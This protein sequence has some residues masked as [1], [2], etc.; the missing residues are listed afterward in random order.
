MT[1]KIGI[2]TLPGNFNYGNRLQNYALEQTIKVNFG[3]VETLI[4]DN[5]KPLIQLLSWFKLKKYELA[6]QEIV[7]QKKVKQKVFIP[8]TKKYLNNIKQK[9]FSTYD[10]IIVGSDQV[11]NP[12]YMKRTDKLKWFLDFV[13]EE[14]RV[15]YAASFGV[16]DIPDNLNS[17]FKEGL[18]GMSQIS[19]REEAGK[20]IVAKI[21]DRDSEL[22][23]DPTM[24]LSRNDWERLINSKLN[25]RVPKTNK[26]VIVYM[27]R[28]FSEE[29]KNAVINFAKKNNLE[30]I[31]IMGDSY[32]ESHVVY[33]PIEF[34]EAIH[35][36]EMIFTDSFHCTVFSIIFKKPFC[37]FDR[38]GG[39]M[40][41][42]LNT[43][44]DRF[45]LQDNLYD[46]FKHSNISDMY[47]KT[48]FSKT[49]SILEDGRSKGLAFLEKALKSK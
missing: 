36:A 6:H 31:Q 49:D 7:K 24:L 20:D 41:S 16:S 4:V 8:F 40:G 11:W 3:N 37:V 1:K 27:L 46:D 14:K 26:F 45:S 44:L 22:V 9:N 19:V 35:N 10:Y 47:T 13:P 38:I 21:A 23:V 30:I 48:D 39:N 29:R 32:E 18:Q 33:D 43:L 12:N 2:L 5:R 28:N 42:R 34:L 15:S 25:S 17:L